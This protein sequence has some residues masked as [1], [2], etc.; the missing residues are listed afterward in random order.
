MRAGRWVTAAALAMVLLGPGAL[1][2]QATTDLRLEGALDL[3]GKVDLAAAQGVLS[4]PQPRI[5]PGTA[6][7]LNITLL[8][9]V[10]RPG[11]GDAKGKSAEP[12]EGDPLGAALGRIAGHVQPPRPEDVRYL[13]MLAPDGITFS[14]HKHRSRVLVAV[15]PYDEGLL[16]LR[17]ASVEVREGSPRSLGSMPDTMA[18]GEQLWL[19][20]RGAGQARATGSVRGLVEGLQMVVQNGTATLQVDTTEHRDG[21]RWTA[22]LR[23]TGADLRATSQEPMMLLAPELAS[24]VEG[25]LRAARAWGGVAVDGA[26]NRA[27]GQA[28]VAQGLFTGALKPGGGHVSM[29]GQGDIAALTLGDARQDFAKAAAAGAGLALAS[30]LAYYGQHLR[31]LAVPLYARIAPSELL[32]NAVRRRVHG[33]IGAQPGADVKGTA[34]AVQVSWSTAAY[35]LARLEREGVVTSRRAGRSKRFFMNG[36]QVTGSAEAIGLLRNPTSHA[37]AQLVAARPGLMQKEI[38]AAL[39]L[40]PSTVSWHMRRLRDLGV[41]REERRWRRAEYHAGPL[42]Q[43]LAGTVRPEPAMPPT[44]PAGPVSSLP[45]PVL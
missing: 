18:P 2:A 40:P 17:S 4:V 37:I 25:T 24:R 42:W 23:W 11:E 26:V 38:G 10:A 8:R 20:A 28:L 31:F 13:E 9:E 30:A 39:R 27:D 36:G 45:S 14:F 15:G 16:S 1:A 33:H 6:E 19:S 29:R 12:I 35:H 22:L 32:D 7:R 21:S 41:V 44:T 3:A 43:E 5:L 34:E